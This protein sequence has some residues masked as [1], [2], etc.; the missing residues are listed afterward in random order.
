METGGSGV[1][2]MLDVAAPLGELWM[3]N[4]EVW[5]DI[6]NRGMSHRIPGTRNRD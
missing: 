1:S 3:D 5:S 6:T 4:G 2:V